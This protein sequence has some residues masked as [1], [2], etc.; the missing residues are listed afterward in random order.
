MKTAPFLLTFNLLFGLGCDRG[1]TAPVPA[2]RAAGTRPAAVAPRVEPLSDRLSHAGASRVVALGDLH[3][4]LAATRRALRLAGAIDTADHWNGDDLVVVQT[5]DVLDRGDD[6]RAVFDLLERLR[7][8]ATRAGGALILLSGNHELMNV[9]RDF[10]YVTPRGFSDFAHERGRG[11][12][13][14]PGGPYAAILASRPIVARVGDTL[15]VHGGILPKHVA[16]GLDRMN[17][18]VRAWILGQRPEPP[19]S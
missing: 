11:A 3:G 18:G 17:D 7:H 16:Y 13:F 5:G 19:R 10:R 6:D 9:A 1:T 12:A 8:E 15:F 2:P 4:D 14:Q